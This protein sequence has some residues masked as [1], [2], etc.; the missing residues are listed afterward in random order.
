MIF[1]QLCQFVDEFEE[2]TLTNTLLRLEEKDK[3][4]AQAKGRKRRKR[5]VEVQETGNT[6]RSS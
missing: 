4:S 3:A 6:A 1:F 5:Q 2:G